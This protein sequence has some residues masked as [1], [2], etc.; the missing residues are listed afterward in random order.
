MTIMSI[1][2]TVMAVTSPTP[3]TLASSEAACSSSIDLAE[4]RLAISTRIL[5]EIF[6]MPRSNVTL[7]W[8]RRCLVGG[9]IK[10][11]SSRGR[12]FRPPSQSRMSRDATRNGAKAE[13]GCRATGEFRQHGRRVTRDQ[14]SEK[15]VSLPLS[16]IDLI[17]LGGTRDA[18]DG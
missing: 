5:L 14:L 7:D 2:V 16:T 12:P 1:A 4:L 18:R 6:E 3:A 15:R 9:A 8:G 11:M 13:C 10:D 17:A